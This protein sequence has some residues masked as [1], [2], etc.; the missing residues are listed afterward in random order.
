LVF[1]STADEGPRGNELSKVDP[2]SKFIRVSAANANNRA[3]DKSDMSADV[4][5]SGEDIAADGPKYIKPNQNGH[6]SG[7]SVATALAAG[8]ASLSLSLCRVVNEEERAN[9]FKD[10]DMMLKLFRKMLPDGEQK[11]INP[12]IIFDG[13]EEWILPRETATATN[14]SSVQ[15]DGHLTTTGGPK[16]QNHPLILP[17]AVSKFFALAPYLPVSLREAY[18][19][20]SSFK[21]EQGGEAGGKSPSDYGRFGWEERGDEVVNKETEMDGHAIGGARDDSQC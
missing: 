20:Q 19:K 10:K 12:A 15:Q 4:L 7:S 6:V 17:S 16:Q 5:V 2:S 13:D 1:W 11:I 21:S 8:I 14:R 3:G 9:K 18:S